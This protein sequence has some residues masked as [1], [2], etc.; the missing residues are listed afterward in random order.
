M[1]NNNK[2]GWTN[3]PT[4]VNYEIRKLTSYGKEIPITNINDQ[5]ACILEFSDTLQNICDEQNLKCKFN[6]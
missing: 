3:K 2:K 4:S 6:K 1:Y 5:N